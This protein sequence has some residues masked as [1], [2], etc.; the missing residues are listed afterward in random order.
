MIGKRTNSTEPI[1]LSDV[2]EILANR[3]KEG[4]L[5]YEQN[6]T[7]EHCK[8][9]S[10]NTPKKTAELV[11]ELMQLEKLDKEHAIAL[12]DIMPEKTEEVKL[13]FAKEHFVLGDEDLSVIIEVLNKFRK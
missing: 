3:K 5:S 2:K 12:A 9:F 7:Y 10:K 8:K 13:I 6:L 1:S 11:T 4:E